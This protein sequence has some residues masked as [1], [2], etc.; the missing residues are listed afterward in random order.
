[1]FDL[2]DSRK[3]R[4]IPTHI[5][6]RLAFVG[7]VVG[8]T[9]I[10]DEFPAD[11]QPNFWFGREFFGVPIQYPLFILLVLLLVPFTTGVQKVSG[12][13]RMR[14]HR[15]A[16]WVTITWFALALALAYAILSQ[17][18][19]P[20]ADWRNLV[21]AGVATGFSLRWL[22]RQVWR[23]EAVLD[24]AIGYGL[25][26]VAVLSNWL[27]GGG[28]AL[29]DQI[30]PVFYWPAL[31]MTLFA[32]LV[33]SS[34]WL[35]GLKTLDATRR[36]G[37]PIG[38]IASSL[39][40]ALSFRRSF[41]LAWVVGMVVVAIFARRNGRLPMRRT[42]ILVG[43]F[44]LVA[45]IAIAAYGA[46]V[47]SERLA[48]FY[49]TSESI[50]SSTNQDHIDDI[51]EGFLQVRSNPILGIGMGRTYETPSL[52][53]WKEISFEV[54]NALVQ[55]WLKFGLLGLVA[56]LGFHWSW[57]RASLNVAVRGRTMCAAHA[58]VGAYLIAQFVGTLTQTWV[59]GR[60][61]M[62]IHLGVVLA[63]LLVTP[64]YLP[65]AASR[66]ILR[67]TSVGSS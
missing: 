63:C 33:L 61:Q 56:Y 46:D 45:W 15:L 27:A 17:A 16:V 53:G 52:V 21:V 54:H 41:W 12:L 59:Y 26:A 8:I 4:A 66:R 23:S 10:G 2:R 14:V 47:L 19:E 29:F 35:G 5:G 44:V 32:S 3:T 30:T 20:F 13:A 58:G 55:V 22:S 11:G 48:S 25:V 38:A 64:S 67:A 50:Y 60:F 6:S 65:S 18:P 36:L 42:G 57:I 51:G 37:V 43:C 9:W 62:G 31:F 39:V 1:L 40:V 28:Q 49:P 34:A 7:I 24:L